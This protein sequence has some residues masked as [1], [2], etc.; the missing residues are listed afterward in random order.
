MR[1]P[2]GV[3][4]ASMGSNLD[5][6]AVIAALWG[7]VGVFVVGFFGS[8]ALF[9]PGADGVAIEATLIPSAAA[10]VGA[11]V[12]LLNQMRREGRALG[13]RVGPLSSVP[14]IEPA[15][16]APEHGRREAA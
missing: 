12:Y 6:A 7:A 14:R 4:S 5:L 1:A 11:F 10:A 16:E 15:A 8:E 13:E 9:G 3:R 2:V